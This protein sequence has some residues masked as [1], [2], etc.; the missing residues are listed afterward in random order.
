M[1][2]N[3]KDYEN[4]IEEGEMA[5]RKGEYE[6]AEALLRQAEVGL[7]TSTRLL[8]ARG[9]V[10][11]ATGRTDEAKDLFERALNI[12]PSDPNLLTAYGMCMVVA[13]K[14]TEAMPLFERVL[15]QQPEHLLALHQLLECAYAINAF[16][17]AESAV[18][19]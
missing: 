18:R 3:T 7:P 16:S 13:G 5:A 11:L 9:A 2:V 8:K 12:S 1:S 17:K 19:R 14:Q 6:I 15:A 4:L 10:C